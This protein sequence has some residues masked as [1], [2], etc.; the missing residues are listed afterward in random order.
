RPGRRADRRHCAG[1]IQPHVADHGNRPGRCLRRRCRP[2][3]IPASRPLR[4]CGAGCAGAGGA[5]AWRNVTYR[6]RA[7]PLHAARA[8][9][10][11]AYCLALAAAALLLSAPVALGAVAGAVLLAGTAAGIGRELRRA[12]AYAIALGLIVAL[13]NALVT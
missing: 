4:A 11:C 7:S 8:G 9:A 13:I 3:P 6:R 10:G 12:L 5:A 2:H 1:V